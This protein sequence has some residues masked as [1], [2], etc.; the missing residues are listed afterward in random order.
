VSFGG[1]R[2]G[3]GYAA[4]DAAGDSGWGIGLELNRQFKLESTWLKQAEPYLLFEAAQ[5]S[6]HTGV[7]SP[8]DLRSI[9]LGVRL[10]DAR[11]YSLD[12]A[13][14]KP[15]GDAA[16]SNPARKPRLS[17]LLSYQLDAP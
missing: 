3:R 15:T 1:A 4:G 5:V 7:P 12:L 14:A 16:A 8:R 17:V 13:V 11:Y 10:S 9:A 6:T 2:F